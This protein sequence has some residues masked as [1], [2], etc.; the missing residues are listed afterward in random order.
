M[1]IEQLKSFEVGDWVWIVTLEDY[2]RPNDVPYGEYHRIVG[3]CSHYYFEVNYGTTDFYELPYCNYGKTWLAYK[4]KEQAEGEYDSLAVENEVLKRDKE[5][6]ERT[7]EEISTALYGANIII[8]S[9]GNIHDKR[10]EEV[11]KLVAKEILQFI[12][13]D[14]KGQEEYLEEN[15]ERELDEYS[16]YSFYEGELASL[17]LI[18]NEVLLRAEKYGVE[19]DE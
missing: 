10:V 19:V 13:D 1:T 17:A 18:E 2:Y 16:Q 4:N 12:F 14:C 11:K 7:L 8:D 6:L 3:T 15:K 5:N 9:D